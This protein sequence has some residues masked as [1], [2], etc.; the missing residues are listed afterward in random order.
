[1]RVRVRV[2]VRVWVEGGGSGNIGF[3]SRTRGHPRTSPPP[4]P[5]AN[6]PH[7][8]ANRVEVKASWKKRDFAAGLPRPVRK[9]VPKLL[10]SSSLAGCEGRRV[11]GPKGSKR[12]R[13]FSTS[14]AGTCS[15]AAAVGAA[16]AAAGTVDL[17]HKTPPV[18]MKNAQAPQSPAI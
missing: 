13:L 14:S 9:D 18:H 1:V 4:S 12:G 17:A 2:R 8:P 15:E 3:Q 11:D 10:A 5:P 7:S 16:P 6:Q